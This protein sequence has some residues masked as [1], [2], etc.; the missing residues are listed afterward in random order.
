MED[1]LLRKIY[2]LGQSMAA[3]LDTGDLEHYF[4]LLDERGTL[5][6]QLDGYRHPSDIDPDWQ[7][8]AL[9]LQEQHQVLTAAIA[10]QERRMQ[11]ELAGMQRYKGASRSYHRQ[12]ARPQILNDNLR[13]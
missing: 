11:E 9:A 12:E 6:D 7:D 13:V 2:R 5:L 10:E 1:S 8:I 3:V 4:Q